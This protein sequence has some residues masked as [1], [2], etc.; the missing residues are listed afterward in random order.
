MKAIASRGL[1]ILLPAL[2]GCSLF[3]SFEERVPYDPDAWADGDADSDADGDSDSSP[4]SFGLALVASVDAERDCPVKLAFGH[5][6]GDRFTDAV[7]ATCYSH[8]QTLGVD[9]YNT[10][11]LGGGRALHYSRTIDVTATEGI[12]SVAV[13]DVNGDAEPELAVFTSH[14]VDAPDRGL[15]S[16][17]HADGAQATEIVDIGQGGVFHD[18]LLT[19]LDGQDPDDI[20]AVGQ[21]P[22]GAGVL[23]A[24]RGVHSASPVPYPPVR[25][26]CSDLADGQPRHLATADFTGGGLLEQIAVI[27]DCTDRYELHLYGQVGERIE[28]ED[29]I[30]VTCE[31]VD[32]APLRRLG[33]DRADTIAVVCGDANRI[34]LFAVRPD[35]TLEVGPPSISTGEY[36][37]RAVAAGDFD[38]D[39]DDDIIAHSGDEIV[40][41]CNDV[42]VYV[43]I[44]G[45]KLTTIGNSERLAIGA[46]NLDV[47]GPP[48]VVVAQDGIHTYQIV[49]VDY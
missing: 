25:T 40:P 16:F 31:A 30:P 34:Q 8:N 39:G 27:V 45:G 24:W 23:L 15:I 2:A 32:L 10:R 20:A 38:E 21:D 26:A 48:E 29:S 42:G 13:G 47:E 28:L 3:M 1:M 11:D 43:S 41:M 18:G 9:L 49:E 4:C 35:P 22:E 33:S 17:F 37:F 6:D 12:V 19:E 14:S 44:S 7:I 46:A 5:L 36:P